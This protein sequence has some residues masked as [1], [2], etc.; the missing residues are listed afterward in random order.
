[1]G[2]IGENRDIEPVSTWRQN[3]FHIGTSGVAL[4]V[5]LHSSSIKNAS[6][7]YTVH[8][9][10]PRAAFVAHT[11]CSIVSGKFSLG[12]PAQYNSNSLF[13]VGKVSLFFPKEILP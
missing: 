9:V 8:Q 1:M 6:F 2:R 5:P 12:V 7:L 3:V 11:A 10:F 13:P 4:V